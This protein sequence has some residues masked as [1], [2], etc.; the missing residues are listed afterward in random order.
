MSKFL[1]LMDAIKFHPFVFQALATFFIFWIIHK[2]FHKPNGSKKL[3][4]SPPKLPIIGNLHQ[5][6]SS[7]PH[8]NLHRLSRK[9]G[10]LML[11]HLGSM[12]ALAVS[13]MEGARAILKTNDLS[14]ADRPTS[15][16]AKKLFYGPKDVSLSPYGE[17]WRQRKSICVLQLLSN[18]R[19][20]S[21]RAI[22]KEETSLLLK[23]I[24]DSSGVL[25]LSQMFFEFSNG[26]ISR[27]MSGHKFSEGENGKKFV[28]L[29][30]DVSS[31]VGAINIGDFIPWLSWV[32]RVNGF[33][34]K[35]QRVAKELDEFLELV[36]QGR[37]GR[38]REEKAKDI[39]LNKYGENFV[40]I[41]LDIYQSNA[42][43]V[44]FCKESVKGILMDLLEG[45]THT[46]SIAQ[47]WMMSEMLRHPEVLKRLQAEV[48]GILKDRV[49]ITDHDLEKMTYL[50]AV[51][52]E[53]LRLHPPIPLPLHKARNDVKLMGYE[54]SAGTW[55]AINIFAIGRDPKIWDE[56]EKFNPDR[57]LNSSIDFKGQDFE[58]IPFSS[59][60]RGCP[61]ISFA[62]ANI[63]YTIANLVQKFE[64]KLAEDGKELDMTERQGLH[65]GRAVPLLALA[66]KYQF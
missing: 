34:A 51:I 47:E 7:L 35:V 45:G 3:P 66:S 30:K 63:E 27:A 25:N 57:F 36:I 37:M 16:V 20:D 38:T 1:S 49:D 50:K 21:F 54:V 4:P 55:V 46:I 19:V 52:K 59:G 60:R 44:S 41:L 53:T 58:L 6:M 2:W 8:H 39:D 61:G 26:M 43:G 40:D 17:N 10:P 5:L 56:P 23:K 24:E 42:Y 12:P 33:K 11:V 13:S 22:R 32:A 64:W 28:S 29:W 48:R 31:S 18:R 62:M 65:V 9:Y 15:W 14:F